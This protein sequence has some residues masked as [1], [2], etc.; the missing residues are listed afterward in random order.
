MMN[1][2]QTFNNYEIDRI[3]QHFEQRQHEEQC[4]IGKDEVWA[5]YWDPVNDDDDDVSQSA[6]WYAV[7]RHV[8]ND[9]DDVGIVWLE[10]QKDDATGEPI[11]IANYLCPGNY[12][13]SGSMRA[14]SAIVKR[15]RRDMIVE[16]M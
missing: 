1:S 16:L 5:I 15:T 10:E 12:A 14:V 6:H 3:E 7:V 13:C 4:K 8:E 2:D 9:S 11:Q